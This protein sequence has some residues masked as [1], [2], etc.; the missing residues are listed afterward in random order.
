MKDFRKLLTDPCKGVKNNGLDNANCDLI[1]RVGDRI[2]SP[3]SNRGQK[4][5]YVIESLLGNGSFGQVLKCVRENSFDCYAIKIL[6][7]HV[8]YNKQAILE[9]KILQDV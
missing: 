8:A 6:K 9:N 1:V 4:Y 2:I 7:N 5:V 3:N